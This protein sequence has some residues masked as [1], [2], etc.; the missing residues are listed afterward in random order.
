MSDSLTLLISARWRHVVAMSMYC[1]YPEA[2][3]LCLV[4]LLTAADCNWSASALW[5][6]LAKCLKCHLLT[7]MQRPTHGRL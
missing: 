2:L 7:P 6:Q 4:P 3:H 5:P 1:S